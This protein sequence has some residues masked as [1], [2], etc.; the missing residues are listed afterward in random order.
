[1]FLQKVHDRME[2]FPQPGPGMMVLRLVGRLDAAWSGHVGDA[3]SGCIQGG[4]H[5]LGID[6]AGV[7]YM[8]SAGIRVLLF[9]SR[10]LQDIGGTFR[11]LNA[12]GEVRRILLLAGLDALLAEK[13]LGLEDVRTG[14]NREPD[15]AVGI[16]MGGDGARAEIHE[17][18]P[19]AAMRVHE[20]GDAES[21]L[22][23]EGDP[24]K[25]VTAE[26]GA[27]VIG[28]GLGALGGGEIHLGEFLAVP[29]AAISQA[30]DGANRP[31]YVLA[32][33]GLIPSVSI[34]YGI[35]GRGS[36]S[37]LLRFEKGAEAPG[38]LM[39]EVARGGLEAVGG[40]AV[41]LV[42][43]AETAS[44][45][46]AALQKIPVRPGTG[47]GMFEFPRVR[48]WLSFTAE[49]AF[50]KSTALVVGIASRGPAKSA[51]KFLRPMSG[52]GGPEGHF[53]AAAF[54]YRPIR[55]GRL[56]MDETI[57]PLFDNESVLGVLHLVNDWRTPN[58]AGE[59]RFL[60]GA[61]WCAPIEVNT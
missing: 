55:R 44:M 50:A 43:V 58:G 9:H 21:W 4:H 59:S 57:A 61:V 47:E 7:E 51:M 8:S 29:G 32:Q 53:H 5:A 10:R 33:G 2:I 46:G 52:G 38:V 22:R 12:G 25:T 16:A 3:I 37:R 14:E 56:A 49:T 24:A 40:D 13:A 11:L 27:D 6:M 23:G 41:A 18:A 36:F 45:V 31:D 35:L 26:F 17:L 20:I 54:P 15:S 42:M 28:L 19:G 60:R 48:E 1:M 34:A 39:S 30:A